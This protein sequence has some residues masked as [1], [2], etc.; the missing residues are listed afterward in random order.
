[1]AERQAAEH[2]KEAIKAINQT[3]SGVELRLVDD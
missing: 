1:M 2:G 3:L